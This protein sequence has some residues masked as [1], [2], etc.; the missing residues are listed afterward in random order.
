MALSVPLVSDLL[1]FK[2]EQYDESLQVPMQTH[3]Q[4]ATDI[5]SL[6]TGVTTD[7]PS[8]TPLGR[9]FQFAILDLAWYIGTSL[10]ERD[11]LYSP[12]SS[13]R[14]GSYCVDEAT[15]ILTMHG[16]K[17]HDALR[18]GDAVLTLNPATGQSEW[19]TALDVHRFD[20]RPRPV[21]RIEGKRFSSLTTMEHRWIVRGNDGALRWTTSKEIA[22][23]PSSHHKVV[24]SAPYAHA[25]QTPMYSDALVEVVAWFWTEGGMHGK[26]SRIHQSLRVNPA[27]CVRI[28]EALTEVFGS[29]RDSLVDKYDVCQ[30]QGCCASPKAR[31]LCN[32]HYMESWHKGLLNRVLRATW[33]ETSRRNDMASFNLSP[34]ATAEILQHFADGRVL[35]EEFLL[36]LTPAQLELFIRVSMLADGSGPKQLAQKDRRMAEAFMF[37]CIL[38]GRRVSLHQQKNGMWQ[39]TL[40]GSVDT[41][42]LYNVKYG[43]AST[44]GYE[45]HQG[46]VWCPETANGTWLARRNGTV[47]FTGNSYQKAYYAAKTG[48]PVGVPF[49]DMVVKMMADDEQ[50]GSADTSTILLGTSQVMA[51][52][53]DAHVNA[54]QYDPD[55]PDKTAVEG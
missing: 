51:T 38:S 47:Y 20:V 27:N 35:R 42:N 2:Q 32:V 46:L 41:T 15:E 21:L 4:I 55:P 5:L 1:A 19:Q 54:Q 45:V 23:K 48:E 25:P 8:D 43:S 34:D 16:W 39:V 24:H 3:L 10:E 31:G 53:W 28:R 17:T 13:E 6:A 33:S 11:A 22:E 12:F 44:F 50:Y 40:T 37:A 14:I 18:R 7:P 36:R 30:V 29:P 9:M 52:T 26:G 49:F